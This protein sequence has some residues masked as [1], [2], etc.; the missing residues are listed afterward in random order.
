[1]SIAVP[2]AFLG[3][4]HLTLRPSL[5]HRGDLETFLESHSKEVAG[6]ECK[7]LICLT[8]EL[9]FFYHSPPFLLK[10]YFKTTFSLK[11]QID[12]GFDLLGNRQQISGKH[13]P[14]ID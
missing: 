6:H 9:P 2:G 13:L 5:T 8:L 11:D 14:V 10:L 3:L 12:E 4:F 7:F 1:M